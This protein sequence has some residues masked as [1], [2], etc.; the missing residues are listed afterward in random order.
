MAFRVRKL[1]GTLFIQAMR[2]DEIMRVTWH[3]RGKIGP[4]YRAW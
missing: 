1:F 4:S 2:T 3:K